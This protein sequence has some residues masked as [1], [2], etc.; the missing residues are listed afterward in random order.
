M[1]GT[2][3][4]EVTAKPHTGCI[5]F[6]RRYGVDAQRFVGSDVG[7]RHRLRGIYVR[8][9]TDGTAGVGDLATKV[10]ATG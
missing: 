9:I 6:V 2:A 5:N 10:N 7:R 1:L 4:V 8:I 3:L